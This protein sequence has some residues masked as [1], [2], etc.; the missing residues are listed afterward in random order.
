MTENKQSAF[1]AYRYPII[2]IAFVLIG[3]VLGIVLGDK[4]S[5]LFPIGQIWLNLLFVLLVPLIF[6]SISSSIS[7]IANTRKVGKLLGLT[8][9]IFIVTAAIAGIFM[10]IVTGIFGVDTS[11][12]MSAEEAAIDAAESSVGQQIVDTF[13]VNDFPLVISRSHILALIV[14]TVF[15]GIIV[16]QL[17]EKGKAI[18]EWLSNMSAIFYKM[19]DLLMKVAPL[20]LMAYFANLT[21]TY[22]ADLLKSY[23]KGLLIY[24]PATI[25]YFFVFLALYAFVAGGSW[26]VKNFFKVIFVP[27][28]TALGTRSSAATIPLQLEA[29]DKLG[30]PREVSSVVVPVGAT[31]HMDGACIATIY[32]IVFCCVMFGHPLHSIGD[33]FFALVVAVA[34][35]VAVSSVPGG[36][37][38]M[39]TMIISSFGF[40]TNVLPVLIM[41]TQLFDAGCTL[42]NSCGDTVASMLVTRFL[43]GKDWFRKHLTGEH[44]QNVA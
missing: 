43:Y 19:V 35:S 3:A 7:N 42:V 29:C 1:A 17:G 31:C 16:S 36:G 41:M 22:G 21:G 23:G 2:L 6:F 26:G 30:V 40:P 4:A 24:Y 38:A 44:E 33:F 28:V 32:E 34:G 9:L 8:I 37:A 15:F 12:Q 25:V 5:F 18:A 14:F 20:G 10:L 39:E 11:V 13:T 27:A